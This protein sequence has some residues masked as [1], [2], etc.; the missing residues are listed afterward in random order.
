MPESSQVDWEKF[1]LN[2]TGDMYCFEVDT[3]NYFIFLFFRF[4]RLIQ[5][6][7]LP[8]HRILDQDTILDVVRTDSDAPNA[9]I[10]SWK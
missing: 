7:L 3:A 4:Y 5:H 9:L 2:M 1:D 10:V 8:N 6:L